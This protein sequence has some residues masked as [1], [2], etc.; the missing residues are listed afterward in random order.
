MNET[1]ITPSV[2]G[3]RQQRGCQR[4]GVHAVEDHDPL[5]LAQALVQL[6]ASDVDRAHR[7]GTLPAAGSR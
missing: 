2:G 3:E 1:S 6:T 5:V 7:D 4:A